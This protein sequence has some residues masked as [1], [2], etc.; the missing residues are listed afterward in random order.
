MLA[1]RPSGGRYNFRKTN[2]LYL[3]T[4]HKAILLQ[5]IA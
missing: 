3:S 4:S 2:K 1:L 5:L